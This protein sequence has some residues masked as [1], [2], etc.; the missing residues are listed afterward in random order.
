[1]ELPVAHSDEPNASAK[2]FRIRTAQCLVLGKYFSATAFG[3][4]TLIL[5]LLSNFIALVDSNVNFWFLMGVI[6]RLAIRMGYHRDPK[7]NPT[8]SP[9][10][11]EMRRRVW[12]TI[13]Q[14]D[15]LISFQMGLPSMIP[16]EYC[17]THPPNNL[18]ESDFHPGDKSLPAPRPL[19]EHTSVRYT[20]VKIGIMRVFKEIVVHTQSTTLPSYA[21]TLEL[22]GKMRATYNSIPEE[23]KMK[24]ISQSFMVP[25]SM[26]INRCTV[27]LLFLK[28]IVVL[29]REY[30]NTGRTNSQYEF[31]RRACVDAAMDI[32]AR[33]A[34][35]YQAAQPAGQLYQERWMMSSL[36]AHDFL[37]AAMVVCLELSVQIRTTATSDVGERL[38]SPTSA[39]IDLDR[40]LEALQTSKR[41]WDDACSVSQE[42][43]TAALTLKFMIEKVQIDKS[44]TKETD[45]PASPAT[46]DIDRDDDTMELPYAD[47]MTDMLYGSE[48][49]NW[50][51]RFT[52]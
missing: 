39:K 5:H 38:S 43:R 49:P 47:S 19:S 45:A 10:E 14:I 13:F 26:I 29:H 33:Q 34:E 15:V 35:L 18:K 23:L 3:L 2:L 9:F 44:R 32:L 16:S 27:E 41:I 28:S 7:F 37:V 8:I 46:G 40:L 21:K 31:S 4:E 12:H 17:D 42:A 50:V 51:C 20:I 1:M 25:S 36:T 48:Y 11:G 6:I 30:L 22:D 52:K 24:P